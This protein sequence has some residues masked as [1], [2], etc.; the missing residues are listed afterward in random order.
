MD[1]EKPPSLDHGINDPET[2]LPESINWMPWIIAGAVLLTLLLICFITWFFQ[3]NKTLPPALPQKDFYPIASRN[4]RELEA[5]CDSS[6]LAEIA[7]QASLAIRA[8]LA[9][10]MSEPALYETA[11][12]FTVRKGNLPRETEELLN[13]LNEAK[14]SR[15][16]IDFERART[17][18][19]R[20]QH[21]LKTMH[22]AKNV[23][24]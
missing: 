19:T 7:A 9:G 16:T 12:E 11:E 15:S 20:S 6:P 8:Y 4:L 24:S 1:P 21:C 14:Y 22:A 17:F 23:I 18:V 10:S 13:D 3:K 2:F 5:E